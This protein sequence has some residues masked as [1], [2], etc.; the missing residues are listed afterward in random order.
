MS[1]ALIQVGISE[2]EGLE[3][4]IRSLDCVV[5]SA[6]YA[7]FSRS[8]DVADAYG[9]WMG[10]WSKN[11]EEMTTALTHIADVVRSIVDGFSQVDEDLAAQLT[12]GGT[13]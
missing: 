1:S 3:G 12:A 2:L 8:G 10:K 6:L 9:D 5:D 13:P 4:R 11:R 7:D